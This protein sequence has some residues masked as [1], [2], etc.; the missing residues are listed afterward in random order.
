MKREKVVIDSDIIAEHLITNEQESELRRISREKFCY[1]TV[2]NAME[3]F[4]AAR[5]VKEK[6]AVRMAMDALKVLGVNPKSAERMGPMLA[7]NAGMS[8][9]LIAGVCRES[10]LPLLTMHPE[11]YAGIRGITVIAVPRQRSARRR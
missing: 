10:G 11:R 7:G 1:T 2:F 5:T 4:A 9:S 8:A 3:L 6:R